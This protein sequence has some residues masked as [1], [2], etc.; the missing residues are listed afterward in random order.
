MSRLCPRPRSPWFALRLVALTGVICLVAGTSA[1]AATSRGGG[2]VATSAKRDCASDLARANGYLRHVLALRADARKGKFFLVPAAEPVKFYPIHIEAYTD[3]LIL[4]LFAG[5][6]TRSDL[7]Y[8][9]KLLSRYRTATMKALNGLVKD[10][11][12]ERNELAAKCASQAKPPPPPPP[13]PPADGAFPGG[14]ATTV[15]LTIGGTTV[16]TDL[17]TNKQAPADA[18]IKASSPTALNG[19]VALNGTLPPGWSVVVFHNGSG[20]IRFNSAT[21]GDFTPAGDLPDVRRQHAAGRLHLRDGGAAALH[22]GG[23]GEYH[24]R[25]GP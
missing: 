15:T 4:E 10:L 11:V 3:M 2:A 7:K 9:I 23:A 5:N 16:T 1:P 25:L 14:T 18:T 20:D 8:R 22:P 6:I 24:D 12:R 19:S 17:K 13:P 21:G